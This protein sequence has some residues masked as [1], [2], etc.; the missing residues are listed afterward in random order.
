MNE[1]VKISYENE[2][3]SEKNAVSIFWI[4]SVSGIALKW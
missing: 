4:L 1:L 2:R 3:Q